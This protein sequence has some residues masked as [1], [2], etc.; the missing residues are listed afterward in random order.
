MKHTLSWV[1]MNTGKVKID[2]RRVIFDTLDK[3]EID[4][5]PPKKRVY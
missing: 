2:Y 5:V 3:S 4:T 1:D